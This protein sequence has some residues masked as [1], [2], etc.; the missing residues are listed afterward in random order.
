MCFRAH[1]LHGRSRLARRSSV[2]QSR[3]RLQPYI[4]I[5][6]PACCT[7][8]RRHRNESG[9]HPYIRLRGDAPLAHRA[10][11]D[12]RAL[13]PNRTCGLQLQPP[14]VS[15]FES[16]GLTSSPC[17]F[18]L[19]QSVVGVNGFIVNSMRGYK[20]HAWSVRPKRYA[21]SCWPTR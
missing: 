12:I 17:A 16:A 19:A 4:R 11:M 21:R 14:D 8:A 3:S 9:L 15:G 20:R 6:T 18:A 5:W 1:R 7:R 13:S 2:R 10:Y